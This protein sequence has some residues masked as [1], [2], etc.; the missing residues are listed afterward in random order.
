MIAPLADQARQLA[1]AEHVI[2]DPAALATYTVDGV[3]PAAVVRPSTA[4]ETGALLAAAAKGHAGV[5]PWGAGVHQHLGGVP[6]RAD[7]VIDTT[8][9]TGITDYEPTDYVVAVRVSSI[10]DQVEGQRAKFYK[11]DFEL[12]DPTTGEKVWIGDHEIKKLVTQ[13]AVKW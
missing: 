2:T 7:L 9:L 1:G 4:E 8:R 10:I 13:K 11:V 5:L 6:A 3:R 12:I